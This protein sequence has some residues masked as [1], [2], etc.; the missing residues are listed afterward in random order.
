MVK[1]EGITVGGTGELWDLFGQ[2]PKDGIRALKRFYLNG[3]FDALMLGRSPDLYVFNT[4]VSYDFYIQALDQFYSDDR[5]KKIFIV[6]AL[7]VIAAE[8]RGV[9]KDVNEEILVKM[10]EDAIS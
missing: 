1:S 2:A 5:N 8:I 3:I 10:R 4:K 9:S 7:Q 6:W